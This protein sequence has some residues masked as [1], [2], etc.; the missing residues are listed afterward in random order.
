MTYVLLVFVL[1]GGQS[2]TAQVP[3]A[4]KDTC[5]AAAGRFA[6]DTISVGET[7]RAIGDHADADAPRAYTSCLQA[8]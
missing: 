8:H 4:D 7:Q 6:S 3:M 2:F 1:W 5:E